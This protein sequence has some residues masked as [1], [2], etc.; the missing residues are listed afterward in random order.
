MA[1]FQFCSADDEARHFFEVAKLPRPPGV[2]AQWLSFRFRSF[3]LQRHSPASHFAIVLRCELG[4]D[5]NGRPISISGRGMT[6]GD[7]SLAQAPADNPYAQRGDFGG[8]RGA[9]CEAFWPGGNF[10]HRQARLFDDGLHDQREYRI[11]LQVDD[12]GRICIRDLDDPGRVAEAVDPL[13]HPVLPERTGVLIALARGPNE[14]GRW[15]AQF[16][17][18]AFGW[19]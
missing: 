15:S 17:D 7:T 18:I 10:L 9:Q 13:D 14:S 2:R 3:D 16:D 4:R 5:A 11:H 8:A 6:W 1:E 19:R 12:D